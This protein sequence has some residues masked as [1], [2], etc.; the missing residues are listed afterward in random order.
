MMVTFGAS[1]AIPVSILF[2]QIVQFASNEIID[3]GLQLSGEIGIGSHLDNGDEAIA[4]DKPAV[5]GDGR[6]CAIEPAKALV[7][8]DFTARMVSSQVCLL[9]GEFGQGCVRVQ[10]RALPADVIAPAQARSEANFK[11]GH[12][13][14][15]CS[16]LIHC[17]LRG[18]DGLTGRNVL[19]HRLKLSFS[20]AN[21]C[22]FVASRSKYRVE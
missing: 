1:R 4:F 21:S 2:F 3:L 9:T 6:E 17:Y 15:V 16:R 8:S 10:A 11:L 22:F 5:A 19:P 20:A 12:Y 7:G 18:N 13:Q 14:K